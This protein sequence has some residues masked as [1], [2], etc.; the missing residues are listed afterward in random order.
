LQSSQRISRLPGFET[1]G[2]VMQAIRLLIVVVGLVVGAKF[3]A[4]QDYPTRPVMII[5]PTAAGG[6]S[7]VLIRVIADALAERLGQP[8]VVENK[9]GAGGVIGA[10]AAA[11]APADGYT[12]LSVGNFLFTTAALRPKMPYDAVKDFTGISL[13]SRAPLVLV[14]NRDFPADTLADV[15][16]AAK[17]SAD[18]LMYT[19]PNF[20]GVPFLSGQL[21]MR[22]ADIK[23]QHVTYSGSPAALI[24][25]MAG[26]VPLMVDLWSS[27]NQYVEAGKLKVIAVV[28]NEKLADA[29]QYPLISATYPV[30]D[31]SVN[32]ALVVAAQTPKPIIE[33]LTREVHGIVA[34]PAVQAR[35]RGLGMEPITSTPEEYNALAQRELSKWTELARANKISMQ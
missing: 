15:V 18:G 23:L 11:K 22:A 9:P 5:Q 4:A 32:N 35:M 28:S 14:A 25:V 31:F 3:A 30:F 33:R 34:M 1:K 17:Q 26:R 12:I 8:V 7:D 16:S 13:L 19:S 20:G 21:L 24:D 10:E 29:P 6:P 27:S 2:N